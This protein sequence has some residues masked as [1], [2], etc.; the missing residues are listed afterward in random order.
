MERGPYS[1]VALCLWFL[2]GLRTSAGNA[3]NNYS[4]VSITISWPSLVLRD[5]TGLW[6]TFGIGL[7]PCC[8]Q[9]LSE[10]KQNQQFST[11]LDRLEAKS[12]CQGRTLE[13]F[14]MYPMDQVWLT[15]VRS[16]LVNWWCGYFWGYTRAIKRC[17]Q[18]T[19]FP[20]VPGNSAQQARYAWS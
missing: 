16:L 3:S 12:T 8:L 2:F 20:Q 14:L 4:I 1:S 10:C 7:Y 18:N 15:T 13:T 17:Y 6:V 5:F 9:V 11:F 19:F